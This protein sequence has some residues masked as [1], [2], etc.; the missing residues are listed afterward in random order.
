MGKV[1]IIG[2]E[3]PVYDNNMQ[4]QMTKI[5]HDVNFLFDDIREA[6][7]ASNELLSILLY[8][9]IEDVAKLRN[10]IERIDNEVNK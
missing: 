9:L 2:K 6:H 8:D 1:T 4:E 3:T 5:L 10:R 7:T